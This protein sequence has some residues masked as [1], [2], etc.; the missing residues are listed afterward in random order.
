MA[1]TFKFQRICVELYIFLQIPRELLWEIISVVFCNPVY[2]NIKYLRLLY[3]V[4][5]CLILFFFFFFFLY[6]FFK[7]TH[8]PVQLLIDEFNLFLQEFKTLFDP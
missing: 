6:F 4:F 3:G 2:L 1:N 8:L 7:L 5:Q